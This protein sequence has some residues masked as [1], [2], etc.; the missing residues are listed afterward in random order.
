[1]KITYKVSSELF[2][3]QILRLLKLQKTKNQKT[4]LNVL[5]KNI[6]GIMVAKAYKTFLLFVD[7]H[8]PN[9]SAHTYN[10]KFT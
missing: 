9:L 6:D 10:L 3:K 1:M 2:T 5:I 8:E 7:S 4:T